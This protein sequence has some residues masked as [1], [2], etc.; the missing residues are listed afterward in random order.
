MGSFLH[1]YV[2]DD[3]YGQMWSNMWAPSIWT[4]L[5]I[6]LSHLH[7][8]KRQT[9]QHQEHLDAIDKLKDSK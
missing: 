5:G 4:L 7:L 1:H 3:L 2:V 8:M 6:G 9:K